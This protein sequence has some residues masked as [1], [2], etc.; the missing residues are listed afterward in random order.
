MLNGGV[1]WFVMGVVL[2]IVA[3]SFKAFAAD[4]GWTITWWKALLAV[5]WYGIFCASFFAW[6]TLI[7]ENEAEAG[8][9]LFA[10]GM[11]ACVVLG[12]GLWRLLALDRRVP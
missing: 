10:I 7:G 1:F 5:A 12:A 2:V 3:F 6:G 4:R 11:F 9:K 8:F